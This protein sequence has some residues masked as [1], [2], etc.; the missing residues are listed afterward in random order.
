MRP[1]TIK[2]E[3]NTETNIESTERVTERVL[4]GKY[5]DKNIAQIVLREAWKFE[6]F[7]DQL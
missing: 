1:K 4:I 6:T 3:A 5:S 7:P 2:V